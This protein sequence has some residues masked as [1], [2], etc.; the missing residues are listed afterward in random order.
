MTLTYHM[1]III[2]YVLMY[3]ISINKYVT[4]IAF[5]QEA[6]S[7]CLYLYVS[8]FVIVWLKPGAF[9]NMD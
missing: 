2:L 6:E 5:L 3:L 7:Q 8:Y 4:T 1:C 9:S